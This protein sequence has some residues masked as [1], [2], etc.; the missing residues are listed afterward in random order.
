MLQGSL[1]RYGGQ[2]KASEGEKKEEG[3]AGKKTVV[4]NGRTL[5]ELEEPDGDRLFPC[6]HSHHRNLAER[7]LG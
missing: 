3:A 4:E 5:G 2:G 1:V 6:N 7:A